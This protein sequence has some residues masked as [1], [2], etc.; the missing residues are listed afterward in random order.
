MTSMPEGAAEVELFAVIRGCSDGSGIAR[1]RRF[2]DVG[3]IFLPLISEGSA[4]GGDYRKR[5]GLSGGYGLACGLH[6]NGEESRLGMA[7]GRVRRTRGT[8]ARQRQ[9]EAQSHQQVARRKRKGCPGHGA[10][11]DHNR[12]CSAGRRGAR[13]R[14]RT[15][16]A[17]AISS[18]RTGSL[19][20]ITGRSSLWSK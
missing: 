9:A 11:Q 12:V 3:A 19:G 16:Q 18:R 13:L 14:K 5:G 6:G 4:S 15:S 8:A 20:S 10:L 1:C 17:G 7:T 2:R